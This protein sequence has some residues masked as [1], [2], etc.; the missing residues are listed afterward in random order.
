M[1]YEL[2]RQAEGGLGFQTHR[3]ICKGM[4][5]RESLDL[6]A[7]EWRSGVTAWGRGQRRDEQ[8]QEARPE[9]LCEGQ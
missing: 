2:A 9:S 4:E 3:S 5:R 6:Y 7:A 1:K 8:S